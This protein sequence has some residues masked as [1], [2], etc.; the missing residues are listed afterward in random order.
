MLPDQNQLRRLS[1]KTL[2]FKF[3]FD[4]V[5][6]AIPNCMNKDIVFMKMKTI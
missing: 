4:D 3:H 6:S 2:E 5:I 1:G